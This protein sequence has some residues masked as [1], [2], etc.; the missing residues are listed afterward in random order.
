M[1]SGATGIFYDGT[2]LLGEFEVGAGQFRTA[3]DIQEGDT[4][5]EPSAGK[6]DIAD[7]I[8]EAYPNNK[9]S[10]IEMSGTLREFIELKYHIELPVLN[11]ES[12]LTDHEKYSLEITKKLDL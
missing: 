4:I 8:K 7:A 2:T 10:T 12:I 9:L 1:D 5:L 3:S 6:G 11:I